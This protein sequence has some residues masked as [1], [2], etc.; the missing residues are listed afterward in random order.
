MVEYDFIIAVAFTLNYIIGTGFL[1][2][3]WGFYKTG[4]ILGCISLLVL[5]LFSYVAVVFILECMARAESVIRLRDSRLDLLHMNKYDSISDSSK[6]EKQYFEIQ[7]NLNYEDYILITKSDSEKLIVN[8]TKFEMS[9]LCFMFLGEWGKFCYLLLLVIYLYSTLWVYATIFALAYSSHFSLGQSSYGIYILIFTSFVI[10][11]SLMEFKEQVCLQV[12]L[13][14]C[15]ILMVLTMVITVI[16]AEKN[17]TN[18]LFGEFQPDAD[19]SPQLLS[20][21][22]K[23]LFFLLPIIAYANIFHHSIP[24][25][26]T[27]MNDKKLLNYVFLT[28]LIITMLSYASIGVIISKYFKDLTNVSSNLNWQVFHGVLNPDGS[29]KYSS[30]LIRTFVVIFPALDVASAFPLNVITLANNLM[31]AF[32][33]KR[34]HVYEKS[35]LHKCLFRLITVVPPLIG[36]FFISNLGPITQFAGLTGHIITFI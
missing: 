3:P 5:S 8:D 24:E 22:F 36:A 27:L 28:A 19:S 20:N 30:R 14:L 10:P 11:M 1:L 15:R 23:N 33:G 21:Q 4:Y 7:S 2:I 6:I 17:T 35:R 18:P 29:E 12:I 32:Y 26:S 13:S 9:E 34:A 16:A 25:L 31:S